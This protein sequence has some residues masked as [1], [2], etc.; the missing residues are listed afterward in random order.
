[1][2]YFF[3]FNSAFEDCAVGIRQPAEVEEDF[4]Y[5]DISSRTGRNPESKSIFY[6]Y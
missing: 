4:F 2:I 6:P 5:P 3:D 1:M